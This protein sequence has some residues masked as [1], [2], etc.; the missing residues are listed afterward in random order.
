MNQVN[1][2]NIYEHIMNVKVRELKNVETNHVEV[3]VDTK[4]QSSQQ[5]INKTGSV[6]PA[7]KHLQSHSCSG[8]RVHGVAQTLS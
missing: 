2:Q 4:L 7:R 8:C 5:A 6:A 3:I 1:K